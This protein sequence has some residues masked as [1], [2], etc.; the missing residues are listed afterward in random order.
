MLGSANYGDSVKIKTKIFELR[1]RFGKRLII[2]SGGEKYGAER[3][4]K[5]HA[6]SFDIKYHEYNSAGTPKNS[7]SMMYDSY[8]GKPW[9]ATQYYHRTNQIIKESDIVVVFARERDSRQEYIEVR[10]KKL[11]KKLYVLD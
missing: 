7:Y 4:V 1:E 10:C 11:Q 2:L 3:F 5:H 9:H 8:Y 6:L